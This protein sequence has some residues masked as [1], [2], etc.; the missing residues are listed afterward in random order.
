MTES[1][2]SNLTYGGKATR[3]MVM[4]IKLLPKKYY[5]WDH[6]SDYEKFF[7]KRVIYYHLKNVIATIAC[8]IPFH[9]GRLFSFFGTDKEQEGGHHY[10]ATYGKLLRRFRY[11]P[12]KFLEIGI[13]EIGIGGNAGRGGVS[14]LAWQAFFPFAKIV[15][16]DI[17]PQLELATWRTRIYATDQSSAIDLARL[18]AEQGPFDV[19]VD[20][21]SHLSA[22]Q[23]FTF[24]KLFDAVT[25]GGLYIVEDVQ[26]SFWPGKVYK[27]METIWDGRHIDDPEFS[28]TCVGYFLELAKYLNYQEFA[29]ERSINAE[30][31]RLAKTIKRISFEHNLIVIEKGRND[32]PSNQLT[33]ETS[34]GRLVRLEA[35]AIE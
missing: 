30:H 23:I 3:A 33:R 7:I 21:G 29:D 35:E 24:G 14:L 1:I 16:C 27:T 20:D 17:V 25:E 15:G 8:I 12:I 32:D 18:T 22:H 4:A 13:G 10:G 5:G 2:H 26:T 9:I 11:R 28:H 19:V 6:K 34:V 31:V